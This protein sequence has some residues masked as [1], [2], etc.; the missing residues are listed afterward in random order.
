MNQYAYEESRGAGWLLFAGILLMIA[1]VMN[2]V[3]GIAAIDDANFYA[4]DAQ[5]QFADLNT[6]GWIILVIGIAQFFAAF[7]IWTGGE[8]GRW[9]GVLSASLNAAAQ[10]FFLPAFPLWSLAIFTLDILVIYGL[11]AYGGRPE[12]TR[13]T[14]P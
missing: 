5:Y 7:S 9:I 1:A 3:G 6:W 14:A 2:V 12:T 13:P 4:A 10:L 8:Y 11:V